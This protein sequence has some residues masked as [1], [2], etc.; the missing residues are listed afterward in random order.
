MHASSTTY[1]PT[2][3]SLNLETSNPVLIQQELPA[4]KYVDQPQR[5]IRNPLTPPSS[6]NVI[7]SNNNSHLSTTNS[8]LIFSPRSNDDNYLFLNEEIAP[9]DLLH[10]NDVN[11]INLPNNATLSGLFF[12][13]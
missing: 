13:K 2:E 6:S 1:I 12:R 8:P 5:N 10:E 11:L 4:G 7:E 3:P 9:N